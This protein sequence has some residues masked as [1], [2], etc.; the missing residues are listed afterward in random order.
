[1]VEPLDPRLF[2]EWATGIVAACGGNRHAATV[3][4]ADQLLLLFGAGLGIAGGL[5]LRH[6]TDYA[7]ARPA[8]PV[9]AMVG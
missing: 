5:E 3:H 8:F 6:Q 2:S 9:T 1:M 4:V 7:D